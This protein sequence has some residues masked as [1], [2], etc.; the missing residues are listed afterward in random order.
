MRYTR[1]N[2]MDENSQSS[3]QAPVLRHGRASRFVPVGIV[4]V[5]ALA[6]LIDYARAKNEQVLDGVVVFEFP[7]YTFYLGLKDC[8]LSGSPYWISPS[9]QVDVEF[10][11]S[12]SQFDQGGRSQF[13]LLHH[14][15]C[16]KLKGNLS[17][18]GRYGGKYW[19]KIDV[20][21][22]IEAKQLNC[23]SQKI[24]GTSY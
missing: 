6:L 13:R 4:C 10:P 5:V 22:V 17:P 23:G 15:W 8:T 3:E 20:S 2:L 11:I 1:Q 18:I 24:D 19:R 16:A 7:T 12:L 9:R 21:Y 14:A